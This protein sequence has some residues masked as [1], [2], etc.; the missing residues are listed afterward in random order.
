VAVSRTFFEE[1]ASSRMRVLADALAKSAAAPAEA[2]AQ[3][4]PRP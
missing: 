4:G 3:Q 2:A 1:N